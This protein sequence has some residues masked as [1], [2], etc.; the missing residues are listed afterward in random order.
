[1]A[2]NQAM[3]E[4]VAEEEM[5][6]RKKQVQDIKK[7][8]SLS[9]RSAVDDS[10]KTQLLKREGKGQV[11]ER[12][13]YGFE[14]IHDR[15]FVFKIG[16]SVYFKE[17]VNRDFLTEGMD[18]VKVN[19]REGLVTELQQTQKSTHLQFN[20]VQYSPVL[21][22]YIFTWDLQTNMEQQL[23]EL[24]FSAQEQVKIQIFKGVS[25]RLNY[26]LPE[27][28]SYIYDIRYEYPMNFFSGARAHFIPG[29]EFTKNELFRIPMLKEF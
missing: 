21:S 4:R 16:N 15:Y 12:S 19:L 3:D 26:Y 20:F 28:S 14:I 23:L 29:R 2:L 13:K 5:R 17:L 8:Y 22:N 24:P 11:E 25:E 9:G 18:R 7:A 1:M 27:S 6:N 10:Q